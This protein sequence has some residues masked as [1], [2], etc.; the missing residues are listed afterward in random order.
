MFKEFLMKKLVLSSVFAVLMTVGVMPSTVNATAG[1]NP[2]G[3]N[4]TIKINTEEIRDRIPNNH[5]HVSCKFRVDF[6]NYD[7]GDYNA[8][9][10]FSLMPPTADDNNSLTVASGNL[11]PFIGGDYAGGGRDLD[12]SQLYTLDFTGPAHDKQG[13]HV[14]VVVNAPGSKGSDK[15]QKVFWVQPCEE[16]QIVTASQ[17]L[18]ETTVSEGEEVANP[19]ELPNVGAGTSA[20]TIGLGSTL[21]AYAWRIRRHK[22]S[23]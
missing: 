2:A 18:G 10:T 15:K 13:Y 5:P 3:N 22:L 21:A 6:Y 11:K 4:G 7:K 20:L 1:H 8:K 17:V 23:I 9:V 14:K 12:A 16:N 19:G